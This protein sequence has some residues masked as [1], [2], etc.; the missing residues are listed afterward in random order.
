MGAKEVFKSI[1][2]ECALC[3]SPTH[4]HQLWRAAE[5]V[6]GSGSSKCTW[7]LIKALIVSFTVMEVHANIPT[8]RQ[9][10]ASQ[11]VALL[12]CHFGWRCIN[13]NFTHRECC[14]NKPW[15]SPHW[16]PDVVLVCK[17]GLKKSVSVLALK[18]LY[19]IRE[20]NWHQNQQLFSA[21]VFPELNK[22]NIYFGNTQKTS[23]LLKS[24]SSSLHLNTC[25][26]NL[27]L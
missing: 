12:P 17:V 18:Y 25:F 23:A 9:N 8:P 10:S 21:S 22:M 14:R 11:A 5:G 20:C 4:H 24:S 7:L 15:P 27:F 3:A 26:R 16:A 13:T 19:G 6:P 2:L 1:S